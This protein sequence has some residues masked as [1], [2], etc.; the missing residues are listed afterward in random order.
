MNQMSDKIL[1]ISRYLQT[2]ASP[3]YSAQ[4]QQ[5]V[6]KNDKASLIKVCK[7][8]KIPKSSVSAVVSTIFAVSP[9]KWPN[10]Y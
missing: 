6:E 8:A 10:N 4:V 9:M 2:L 3:A 7:A 5:A 1:D